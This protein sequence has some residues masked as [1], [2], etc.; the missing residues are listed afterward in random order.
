MSQSRISDLLAVY[1]VPRWTT[2]AMQRQQN[3]AEHS[4]RVA[5]FAGEIVTRI[6]GFSTLPVW[7]LGAVLWAS[8]LH[9]APEV[10]TGDIPSCYKKLHFLYDHPQ[11]EPVRQAMPWLDREPRLSVSV[12]TLVHIADC[13]EALHWIVQH[14]YDGVNGYAVCAFHGKPVP[15][16]LEIKLEEGVKKYQDLT[17]V[18]LRGTVERIREE[19]LDPWRDWSKASTGT[20]QERRPPEQLESAAPS[21]Q[22]SSKTTGVE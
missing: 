8:V 5:A 7:Y 1:Q 21:S 20:S 10:V 22:T 4:Y 9:D 18:D 15:L 19:L 16:E 11:S 12:Y 14:G 17:N 3:V 13:L 6:S 2:I